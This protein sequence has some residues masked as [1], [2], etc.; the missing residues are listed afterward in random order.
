MDA[1][2]ISGATDQPR[3]SSDEDAAAA[4]HLPEVQ[5]LVSAVRACLNALPAIKS[6]SEPTSKSAAT[7]E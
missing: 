6:K 4:E 1:A 2:V 7:Q 5:R 3:P